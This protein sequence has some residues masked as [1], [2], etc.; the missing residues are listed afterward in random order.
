MKNPVFVNNINLLIS[1]FGAGKTEKFSRFLGVPSSAVKGWK[2]GSLPDG[3]KTLIICEKC[4]ITAR[5][6]FFEETVQKATEERAIYS[7][8]EKESPEIEELLDDARYVLTSGNL[9]AFS[10]LE[11]NIKYFRHAVA[12]ESEINQ[13][14]AENAD[15]RAQFGELKAQFEAF[16]RGQD[17]DESR[18]CADAAG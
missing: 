4:G 1:K 6:L 2:N 7:S 8:G 16:K 14:R 17:R 15:L 18:D 5:Q 11:R 12:V 3:V 10:A 9:L 13:L